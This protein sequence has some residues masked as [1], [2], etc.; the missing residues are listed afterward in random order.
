MNTTVT[1]KTVLSSMDE[2]RREYAL[3]RVRDL[4]LKLQE[5]S[6]AKFEVDHLRDERKVIRGLR[7]Y[8]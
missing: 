2:A 5:A 3:S 4:S 6:V 7:V 8:M 1:N